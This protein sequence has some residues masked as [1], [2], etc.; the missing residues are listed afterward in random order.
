MQT[1]VKAFALAKASEGS[2]KD[3]FMDRALLS[4]AKPLPEFL[5]YFS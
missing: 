3:T 2:H 5:F 1:K 4:V